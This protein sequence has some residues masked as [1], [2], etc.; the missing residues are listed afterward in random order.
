MVGPLLEG[1]DYRLTPCK[2]HTS[3]SQCLLTS[4]S[5]VVLSGGNLT[6][7]RRRRRRRG[8]KRRGNPIVIAPINPSTLLAISS[9]D[10]QS[11][12]NQ[13]EVHMA[14]ARLPVSTRT[15]AGRRDVK[16]T[17][18]S[19]LGCTNLI[20]LLLPGFKINISNDKKP[21]THGRALCRAISRQVIVSTQ[22][23][24]ED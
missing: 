4:C 21:Y 24:D 11:A 16:A 9:A 10:P 14:V 12:P 5:H 20:K 22:P 3:D 19:P 13:P 15:L 2:R 7:S 8:G 17:W 1:A 23:H 18:R 6:T